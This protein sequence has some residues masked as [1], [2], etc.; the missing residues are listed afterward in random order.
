MFHG[1]LWMILVGG[2]SLSCSDSGTDEEVPEIEPKG[3]TYVES[4]EVFPNPE[5]GFY[6][7]TEAH[8]PGDDLT[9]EQVGSLKSENVSLIIRVYY[10]GDYKDSPI[11]EAML[12]MINSDME[13]VRDAGIKA[14]LRFAYT[15]EMEGEDA[16]LE[17]VE[18]HVE[19]LAPVLNSNKDVI[20]FIQAGFIGPWGEWHNSSNG[21]TTVEN[22]RKVLFKLLEVLSSDLLVQVRTPGAKQRIFETAEPIGE[23]IA[24]TD[25]FRARVGHHNDCFM[26]GVD[27]YGTYGNIEA[28]KAYISQEALYVP[29]GGETCPPQGDYPDCT[30]AREEMKLLR[31]TY[32]NRDY[33][34]PVISGWKDAGCL[35]EFK[36]RLGYRLVLESAILPEEVDQGDN[37]SLQINLT[38]KGFAPLYKS[39]ITS[40]VLVNK[41]SGEEYPFELVVDLR[42]V[43]PGVPYTIEQE[44]EL[45]GIP[46]GTYDLYLEITDESEKLE[47][48]VGYKVR[49]A[50][51]DSWD[52]ESGMNKLQQQVTVLAD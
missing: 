6:D 2:L 39:K 27:D 22:E 44:V 18:G 17:T 19:Q 31:W 36:R 51:K 5:R 13:T 23:A 43:K 12:E 46:V 1:I 15:N 41:A 40:L 21:L 45:T 20:A 38:N 7:H 52:A 50:N 37:Y 14:I 8:G 29:T 26:A 4:Q 42:E 3:I 25:E 10:L 33:Y 35:D 24:Y 49:L 34:R 28:E 48:R 11:D 16:P 9:P 47:N 30:K 32:L